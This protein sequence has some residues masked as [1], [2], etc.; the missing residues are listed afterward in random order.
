M[1]WLEG[2]FGTA[3]GALGALFVAAIA[4]VTPVYTS[5]GSC[6]SVDGG[7]P[8]CTYSQPAPT[9]Q[10]GLFIL[11]IVLFVLFVLT[12]VGTWI[13][14]SGRRTAGRLILLISVTL[15]LPVWILAGPAVAQGGSALALAY[16]L[17]LLAF[18][19]GILACVRR[20][21][22]RVAVAPAMPA[23]A[24]TMMQPPAAPP[25]APPQS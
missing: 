25:S 17:A 14:L 21:T 9:G 3:S 24:P 4:L 16:P 15:L 23:P 19:A 20:D 7:P 18:V 2:W 5:S 8:N 6:I 13:D 11:I 10:P 22:P 12:V 1:R